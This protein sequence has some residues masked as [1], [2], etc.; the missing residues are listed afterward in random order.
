METLTRDQ[1]VAY[2]EAMS[3]R[4]VFVT[5]GAG[6][7]KSY[8]LRKIVEGLE[9]REKNVIVCATT[10]VAARNIEGVTI[11]RA[12]GLPSTI[13]ITESKNP[14][15]VT[16][17]PKLIRKADA[18]IIDEIS[19]CSISLFDAVVTSIE[20][21]E[22]VE[23]KKIQLIVFGDFF[24]LPPVIRDDNGD[25]K[26]IEDFYGFKIHRGFA[27]F[28]PSWK[29]R[30][31][32]CIELTTV[33]RQSD[34]QFIRELNLLRRGDPACIPYLNNYSSKERYEDEIYLYPY[35]SQVDNRNSSALKNLDQPEHKIMTIFEGDIPEAIKAEIEPYIIL[36]QKARVVFT[37]SR[38][39]DGEVA[40]FLLYEDDKES[41]EN[42]RRRC[43]YYNGS[44]GTITCISEV[45]EMPTKQ[46]VH[47]W[48]DGG[49]T[50]PVYKQKYNIYDYYIDDNNKT[51]KKI[52]GSYYQLP[53]R[54][55]YAMTIHKAQGNTFFRFNVD[56]DCRSY[57]QLYVAVSRAVSISGIY[58]TAYITEDMIAAD[59]DVLDFYNHLNDENW[60]P[61]KELIQKKS[62]KENAASSDNQS[63]NAEISLKKKKIDREPK[64][65]GKKRRFPTG[66]K[67]TKIPMELVEL[68]QRAIDLLYPTPSLGTYDETKI[69]LF[70]KEADRLLTEATK[71]PMPTDGSPN[72]S[73]GR[74]KRFPN[75]SKNLRIPLEI[76]KT[77]Q[78]ILNV[79]FPL[80]GD[81][82]FDERKIRRFHD[83]M[84][85]F[86]DKELGGTYDNNF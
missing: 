56:P 58:F 29:R 30:H 33:L 52:I 31:F 40:L 51:R 82:I 11:H 28:A 66:D 47:V 86:L 62:E 68:I 77:I 18:I 27:F 49:D 83:D 61:S 36:K 67:Q 4:N 5:G 75:D 34:A 63:Q 3:G 42:Y 26:K 45:P 55:A 39:I 15:I 12:F 59:P 79:L 46:Y 8:I 70:I 10:G 21:A 23:G 32:K 73:I 25:R 24:Q 16:R 35:N 71:I 50:V 81:G 13:C 43:M 41:R 19:M 7:G 72:R 53:M 20:K 17:A 57:G 85:R 69:K 2:D 65:S 54:L 78:Q 48:L 14:K 1:R 38:P 74:P 80:P 37:A 64:K 22:R 60:E 44:M 6:V 9:E 76:K 84:M